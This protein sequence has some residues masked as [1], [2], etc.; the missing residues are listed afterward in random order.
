MNKTKIEWC[1]MTWNPVTGCLHGCE[2]CYARRIANRFGG[3]S[4]T[5]CNETV[6]T[7]CQWLTEG[8]GKTHDLA[9]PV[10]D[11]DRGHSAPYPF[12][13]DPTF[14]RYRLEELQKIKR[15]QRVFVCS[16]ADLFGK[17]VPTSWIV[18]VLDACARA[19][20]HKYIFLTKNPERYAS[21]EHLALLPHQDNFWYGT[22][23]TNNAD[24]DSRGY[25]LFEAFIGSQCKTFL[26]IEPLHECIAYN[27]IG[28]LKYVNWVIVGA[29]S[30][31]CKGK[32]VPERDWIVNII[33]ACQSLG[34][35][36]FMK[37]SLIPII[38]EEN[39][40]REW[41]AGL[42]MDDHED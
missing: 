38:G 17:W 1:D 14:H 39:M 20:Q 18:E 40:I 32:I 35:P 37:D 24:F 23:L 5:H 12:E 42:R 13:F 31:T 29:E 8:T 26:S 16:M 7:E 34:I 19:P 21:L 3:A 6:G 30:G 28:N 4:E 33:D 36:L 2:Y 11:I 9:E 10:Y 27:R 25:E 41:P 22:T 15:P